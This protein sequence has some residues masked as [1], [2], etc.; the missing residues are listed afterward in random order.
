MPLYPGNATNTLPGLITLA[1]D[2]GGTYAL[3]TVVGIR[4]NP[5]QAG[6]LGVNQ[7]GYV[8]TW[9]N[10]ATLL[11]FLPPTTNVNFTQITQIGHGFSTGQAVYYTGSAWALAESNNIATLGIGIISVVNPNVFDLYQVGLI[12]GLSGLTAGQYYFVSDATPGLLTST[13]PSAGTSFSN[14]LFFALSTTTGLVL[15]FRPSATDTPSFATEYDFLLDNEPPTTNSYATT[16]T[17]GNLTYESWSA[18][19][20]LIKD[21]TYTFSGTFVQTE[22]RKVYAT[23]GISVNAELTINYT[24]S[25]NTISSATYTRNI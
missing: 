14:P 15:P 16:Y 10:S 25:G 22:V 23:N 13:Q 24:Y 20:L 9:K 7:D 8:L 4:T 21:I 1:G 6:V 11:E 18:G 3:P 17:G 12:S 2:L 5:V 19:G